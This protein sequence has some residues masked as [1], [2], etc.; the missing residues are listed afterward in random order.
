[1]SE[2]YKTSGDGLYFVTMTVVGWLDVFTRREY[3]QIFIDSIIF[4]QQNKNLKVYCYCLMPSHFHFITYSEKG[5]ISNILRDMKKFT[6]KELIQAIQDNPQESRKELF[7]NQFAYYGKN[8][9][10]KQELQFW[11]HEN[12]PFFLFSNKMI[13]Q[14]VNY[15]LFNPVEAGFVN[16]PQ[17]WRLSSANEQSP[18][19]IDEKI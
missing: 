1:M 19:K 4:C 17:E 5:E 15:I 11:Q 3:Q 2:K 14:K 6:A 16:L 7:L 13:Q 9:G 8:S 18:I 10:M 12:H